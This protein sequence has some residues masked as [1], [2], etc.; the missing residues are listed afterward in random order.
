M[1]VSD[2]LTSVLRSRRALR[3]RTDL[4][5]QFGDRSVELAVLARVALADR[6]L[7]G[8]VDRPRMHLHRRAVA[9][10]DLG[11]RHAQHRAVDERH[12]AGVDD[13]ARRRLADHLAE[14]QRAVAF[15]E[16]LGV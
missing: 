3:L 8:D 4:L 15:G 10:E 11:A 14:L 9:G 6:P 2:W 13:P 5:E 7:H 12:A 16:V 1:A